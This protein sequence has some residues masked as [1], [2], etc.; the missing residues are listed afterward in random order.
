M[1]VTHLA[2]VSAWPGFLLT[3]K[4]TVVVDP[5][6]RSITIGVELRCMALSD[7]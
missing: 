1:F 7:T 3:G 2:G 6:T 4:Q 5:G